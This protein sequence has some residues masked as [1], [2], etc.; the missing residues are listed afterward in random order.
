MRLTYRPLTEDDAEAYQPL[1]ATGVRNFPLGFLIS[2]EDADISEARCR[3]ILSAGTMRGVFEGD[4]LIGFCG[5]Q[6]QSRARTQHRAELGPFF[7]NSSHHGSGAARALM[8][9]VIEEA[10]D[11]GVEQLELHVDS[12]NHRAIRFYEKT[13]FERIAYLPDMVRINGVTRND[14]MY[15]MRL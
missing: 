11:S 8:Q 9:G 1:R 10:R 6:R 3:K 5:Y 15:R 7:I 2:V 14:H 13:G 12:E 4:T